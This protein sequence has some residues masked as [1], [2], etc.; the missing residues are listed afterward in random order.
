MENKI[1]SK[2]IP[3]KYIFVIF[4]SSI[5]VLG[6]ITISGILQL[7]KKIVIERKI[8]SVSDKILLQKIIEIEHFSYIVTS[9]E[10]GTI[11]ALVTFPSTFNDAV[12]GAFDLSSSSFKWKADISQEYP[13]RVSIGSLLFGNGMIFESTALGINAF[14]AQTGKWIWWTELGSGHVKIVQQMLD[15]TMRVYYGDS[16]FEVDTKSGKILGSEVSRVQQ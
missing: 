9:D 1:F 13:N 16:V 6:F 5:L 3:I 4:L 8:L 15:S 7:G 11:Y 10:S 14:E 2:K 12:I